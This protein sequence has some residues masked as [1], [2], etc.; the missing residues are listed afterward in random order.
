MKKIF[1]KAMTVLS[2]V[3]LIGMT[4]GVAS[5]AAYPAPFTSNTAIVVGANAAPSDGIAASLIAADLDANAVVTTIAGGTITGESKDLNLG[6]DLLYLNDDLSENVK[7]LTKSDLPT[8]LADNTFTDEDGTTYD[9]Y[10]TIAVGASTTN[11]FA[12]SNSDNDLDDPALILALSS[13]AASAEMYNLT[14]NFKKAVNFTASGSEG[15]EIILF[16]KTYTVGTATDATTLVLLGGAD[17]AVIQNGESTTLEVNGISYDVSLG[18]LS[19]ATTT[20]AS[21]TVNGETRTFTQGQTKTV[22]GIDVYVKTVFRE[23]DALGYVEVQLGADKLTLVTASAVQTGSDNDDIDETLVTIT[24]TPT[25]MTK[26]VIQVAAKDNDENHLLPG[27]SFVDRVFGTVLVNFDNVVNGPTFTAEKDTGRATLEITRGQDQELNLDVTDAYG[28]VATNLPFTYLFNLQDDN[29]ADIEIV[30]GANLTKDEY[31]TLNSGNYQHFMQLTTVDADAS[32]KVIFKDQFTGDSYGTSANTNFTDGTADTVSINSQDYTITR[33]S[34]SIVQITSSD[35]GTNKAVYPYIELVSGED[36]RFAYTNNV[37]LTENVPVAGGMIYDLPTGSIQFKFNDNTTTSI[38]TYQIDSDSWVALDDPTDTYTIGSVD[39]VIATTIVNN[40]TM[41][42]NNISLEAAQNSTLEVAETDPA[43]LFVEDEDKSE[44]TTTT[45]NA[46]LISMEDS[47]SY[48]TVNTP[49][50]TATTGYDTATWDDTKFTG[51][52]TNYGTY[53]WKDTSDS[54]QD[55]VGLSYADGIMYA[56]VS[57]AE[58]EVATTT[59]TTTEA[60]VMTVM[61]GAVSSVA[62]KHLIVVGGSAINSVAASLL[63]AAYSEAAFTSATGVAAGEFLIQSFA[64]DGKT[65][66]LVAGYNAEDTEKAV[67]YLLHEDV[68]TTTGTKL[69]G[70]SATEAVTVTV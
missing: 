31:F 13:T 5:A 38:G 44:T 32:G 49:V 11:D 54:N 4:V 7:T 3:A 8:V 70:T 6:S 58:G 46:I 9:Y 59:S 20:Q 28:N 33:M 14:V 29:G 41:T 51:W 63:G 66:L 30:E 1:K 18:G 42:V 39:Y 47:S 43:I 25:A 21:V 15:E 10:Q 48:D 23:G 67:T 35:I 65:A 22:A 12:F 24:G 36:T 45:K 19:S 2:G 52:L 16:G 27:E 60:G 50:F 40:K 53:V 55:L 62:G 61:D 68:E 34:D 69:K 57:F 64:R 26:L 37:T 56:E 17:S